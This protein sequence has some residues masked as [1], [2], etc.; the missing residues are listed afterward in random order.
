MD[1]NAC[2]HRANLVIECLQS[3][4]ITRMKWLAFS[5]NMIPVCHVFDIL[6]RRVAAREPPPTCLLNPLDE[7][8]NIP[9]DHIDNLILNVPRR[10]TDCIASSWSHSM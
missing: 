10:C 5:P 7:W 4:N 9:Q 3:E 2:P 8:C 1:G 6:N